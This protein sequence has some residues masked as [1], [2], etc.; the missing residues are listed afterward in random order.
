VT[1]AT[2][3]QDDAGTDP[4]LAFLESFKKK[5][6][7]SPG[8]NEETEETEQ[9]G[10]TNDGEAEG[11]DGDTNTED[12][13]SE[14]DGETEKDPKE[15]SEPRAAGD[16]DIVTV[17]VGDEEHRVSVKDLRRLYGQEAALTRKSQEVA[18]LRQK[19]ATEADKYAVGLKR[20]HDDAKARWDEYAAI[21]FP[22]AQR[23][24]SAE[25][26]AQLRDDA[27][28]AY[29]SFKFYDQE[30]TQA[31]EQTRTAH[32][33]SIR[34]AARECVVALKDETSPFHI[35]NWGDQVYDEMRDFGVSVGLKREEVDAIV[36][37]GAIKVLHMAMQY[38]KSQKAAQKVTVKPKPKVPASGQK[39]LGKSA[40]GG[41]SSSAPVRS[42]QSRLAATG[43]ID[44]AA[45]AFLAGWQSKANED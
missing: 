31:Q 1:D 36:H 4:V 8:E 9:E 38:A 44:D 20:M 16:D 39:V 27:T 30:L 42:A 15:P 28:K 23:S 34:T 41:P 7:E 5:P 6:G 26:F 35:E 22:T 3:S 14:E 45:N 37:P 21:D 43:K 40:T 18:D 24:M 25:A 13:K 12:D 11:S 19:V 33:E 10:A 32:V 29:Q 17:K 2:T